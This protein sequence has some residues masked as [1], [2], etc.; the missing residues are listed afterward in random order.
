M[1]NVAAQ[2]TCCTKS[3]F[4]DAIVDEFVGAR[5]IKYLNRFDSP[6]S[7]NYILTLA[8]SQFQL[9]RTDDNSNASV[10][11]HMFFVYLSVS[12]F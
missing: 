9:E 12:L 2:C 8:M 6:T 1:G 7:I 11:H 5:V 3:V 10:S 4:R